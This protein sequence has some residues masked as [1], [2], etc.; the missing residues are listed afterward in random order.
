MVLG[1]FRQLKSINLLYGVVGM[2]GRITYVYDLIAHSKF[3]CTKTQDPLLYE[4]LK[5][6][7]AC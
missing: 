4:P 3:I 7:A 2:D 6:T 1:L 5:K